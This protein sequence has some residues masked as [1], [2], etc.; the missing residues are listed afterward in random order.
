MHKN[1]FKT[2]TASAL[3]RTTI[4]GLVSASI[5]VTALADGKPGV[6]TTMYFNAHVFTA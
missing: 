5:S 3:L 4:T 2:K 6:E 1:I